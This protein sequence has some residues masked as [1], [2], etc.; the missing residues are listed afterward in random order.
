METITLEYDIR[1]KQAKEMI[2]IILASGLVN[3]KQ[4]DMKE[5]L[6]CSATNIAA[7]VLSFSTGLWENYDIDDQM[8]RTKAW[9]THK[10]N[11]Q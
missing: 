1:N 6:N 11:T 8:L 4:F 2:E 9:G 3:R 5:T 10:R 7:P